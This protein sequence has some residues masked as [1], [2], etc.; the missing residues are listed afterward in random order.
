M[1]LAS[2][3]NLNSPPSGGVSDHHMRQVPHM[4]SV[5]GVV[6]RLRTLLFAKVVA[7]LHRAGGSRERDSS[8]SLHVTSF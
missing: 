3:R 2:I 7:V 1:S 4:E 5:D 8:I 6:H